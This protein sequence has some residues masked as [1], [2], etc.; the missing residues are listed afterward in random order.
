VFESWAQMLAYPQFKEFSLQ[1]LARIVETLKSRGIPT[2]LFARGS[3]L[4]AHDLASLKPTALSIDWNGH[5]SSI[6]KSLGKEIVLQGNLDPEVLHCS[7]KVVRQHVRR[8]LDDMRGDP[9]YIFNLGHGITPETP[10]DSV[11][12]LVDTIHES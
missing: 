10:L 4:L 2:I 12:A 11:Q 9:A 3:S 1:Y 8:L 6:R 5:L 7:S